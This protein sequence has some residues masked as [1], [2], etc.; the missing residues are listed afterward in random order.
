MD[1]FRIDNQSLLG[2]PVEKL[3]LQRPVIEE[4]GDF[5]IVIE[6][7]SDRPISRVIRRARGDN[8]VHIILK[9][10]QQVFRNNAELMK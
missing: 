9:L 6:S 4:K 10:N 2:L 7:G 5:T 1:R 8:L 3:D